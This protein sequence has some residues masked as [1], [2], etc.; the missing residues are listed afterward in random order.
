MIK[1]LI[2]LGI[3]TVVGNAAQDT[4][5]LVLG[6][7]GP[8]PHLQTVL[9]GLSDM[10]SDSG[11]LVKV[12]PGEARS[13]SAILDEMKSSGAK[14]LLYIAVHQ[15]PRQRGKIVAQLFVDG[16]SAWEEEV[17]G[18]FASF[19][20]EGEV[21]KM[22]KAITAKVKDHIGSKTLPRPAAREN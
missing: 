22:L 13:R 2:T 1:C 19:S 20:A 5:S 12:S 15:A 4:T 16:K 8:T 7:T 17:R 9:D 11:I 14:T 6:G 21:R 18:G 3:L 10:L